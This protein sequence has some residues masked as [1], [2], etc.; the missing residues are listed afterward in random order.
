MTAM[1]L[2]RPLEFDPDKAL[3]AALEV[4]WAKGYEATS[5]GDLLKA[6]ALSKSS[7]Y[8]TFGG[9]RELFKRCLGRYQDR[10]TTELRERL[11]RSSSGR[12]FI[13]EVFEY[14]ADTAQEP[15]GA[16]GCL[17]ANSA[18]E[19]GQRDSGFAKPVAQG[20]RGLGLVFTEAL[21]RAQAE[22]DVPR[23]ADLNALASYLVS[24]M[25]GLR[26]LIKT[27]LEKREARAMVPLILA[28]L[29]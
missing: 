9:K 8:Q 22:G 27:G 20:L 11:Q 2:G 25:T 26:T 7:L 28:A 3:D 15:E 21:Y 23:R 18:S 14:V 24:S 29:R 19:F 1:T 6:M 4:F 16:K 17:V 5:M 10:F 12:R 13:E